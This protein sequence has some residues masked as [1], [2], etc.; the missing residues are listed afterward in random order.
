MTQH[1]HIPT[2]PEHERVGDQV[3]PEARARAMESVMTLLADRRKANPE[4]TAAGPH[5]PAPETGYE[6]S[7]GT[8]KPQ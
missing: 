6:V 3:S 2:L 7:A 8:L 4:S 1:N 5:L